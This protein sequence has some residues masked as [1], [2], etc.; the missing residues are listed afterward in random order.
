MNTKQYIEALFSDYEET[1]ALADFKEEL[2]S[3]LNDRIS[4]LGKKGL[5]EKEAYDKVIAELGDISTLADE[6]SLKKKQQVFSDRYMKTRR[7]IKPWRMAIYVLCGTIFGFGVIT[8]ISTWMFSKDIQ[9]FLGTVLFF[10]EASVLGLVF[11]GLTQ[12]TSMREAM[13]WKRALWYVV[14]SGVFLFGV[15]LFIMTYFADGV[16]LPHAI[17][18]L[19]PFALPS[20]A[21]GVFLIL[22]EKDRSKPWMRE[23]RKKALER[24]MNRFASPVEQERFG[25]ISG[26]IWIGGIAIFILLTITVGIKFSWLAFVIALIG[27]M[28]V[29]SGFSKQN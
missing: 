10:S 28:L 4:S 5:S 6:L 17:A 13:P 1:N 23:L 9:A 19:I 3:N 14:A 12:E 21:L 7:Y 22:T 20:L 8:G 15:I 26:A 18:S 25:L 16:G 27:Q 29:L 24:E 2:E 11:L